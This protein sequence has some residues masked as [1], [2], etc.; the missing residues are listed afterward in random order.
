MLVRIYCTCLMSF[1]T[2]HHNSFWQNLYNS[3]IEVSIG[4]LRRRQTSISLWIGHRT[5]NRKVVLL[6]KFQIV[7]KSLVIF[8]AVLFVDLIC[9]RVDSIKG[10][11]SYAALKTGSSL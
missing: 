7:S 11:H 6:Y 5:V 4:L 3:K 9:S 1:C 10:I 2:S 8:C